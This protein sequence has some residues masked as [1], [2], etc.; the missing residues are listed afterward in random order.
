MNI[1]LDIISLIFFFISIVFIA[2][3]VIYSL[4]PKYMKNM[5]KYIL[6]LK[7]DSIRVIGL[8]F[9]FIGTLTLYIIL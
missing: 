9:I 5:F 7:S 6:T 1:N 3:G 2:E 8:L 4:F